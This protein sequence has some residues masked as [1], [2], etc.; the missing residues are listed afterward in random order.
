MIQ[1]T[2]KQL[3]QAAI[4]LWTP[5][6]R[7]ICFDCHGNTINRGFGNITVLNAAEMEEQNTPVPVKEGKRITTCE[8]CKRAIQLYKSIAVE[9]N[10]MLALREAGI[11]A[12]MHQ[13]GGMNSA[14]GID[15]HNGGYFLITYDWD[16]DGMFV[17]GEYDKEGERLESFFQSDKPDELV[18]HIISLG[19]IKLIE[20]GGS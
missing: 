7:V 10:V 18:D 8:K 16:G 3:E 12:N 1:E 19:T 13:T 14:C 17:V 20:K 6:A 2:D 4:G 15:S 11:D 5:K 9:H